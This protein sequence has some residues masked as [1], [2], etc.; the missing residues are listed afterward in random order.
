LV[1]GSKEVCLQKNPVFSLAERSKKMQRLGLCLNLIGTILF[2]WGVLGK[3]GATWG[4]LAGRST[5]VKC[6]QLFA[7]V[8]VILI[9][10]GFLIQI[11][12]G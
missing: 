4:D 6:T 11:C 3:P 10:I 8:G 7:W 9:F 1:L 12:I 2:G 5:K